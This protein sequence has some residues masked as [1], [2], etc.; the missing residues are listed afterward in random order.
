MVVTSG[1]HD[2]EPG[3]RRVYEARVGGGRYKIEVDPRRADGHQLPPAIVSPE[4]GRGD[5]DGQALPRHGRSDGLE[6]LGAHQAR[7]GHDAVPEPSLALFAAKSVTV[8]GV[9]HTSTAILS[10]PAA[11][12]GYS[13]K[14]V[15]VSPGEMSGDAAP[16]SGC[17]QRVAMLCTV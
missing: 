12:V 14:N 2:Q 16:T 9:V 1:D 10:R 11:G 15:R 4:G 17:V 5:G 13:A 7:L 8:T 3:R 6:A